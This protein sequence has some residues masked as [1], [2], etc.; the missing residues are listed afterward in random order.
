MGRYLDIIVSRFKA[1]E[2]KGVHK[3]GML[4]EDN[5]GPMAYRL[6][7]LAQELTDALMYIEW[8]KEE[9]DKLQQVL[10]AV[11]SAYVAYC[12]PCVNTGDCSICAL[13]NIK[14]AIENITGEV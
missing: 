8:H 12:G 3:Y 9:A 11:E 5:R 7:H 6:E 14:Q 10:I 13:G 2:A 4:L 1:Q